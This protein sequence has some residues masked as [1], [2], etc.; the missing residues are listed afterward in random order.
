MDQPE[1][2][3]FIDSLIDKKNIS[4]LTDEA[5]ASIAGELKELLAQQINRAILAQ[6][7]DEKLDEL[8]RRMDSGN[9]NADD[10]QKFIN[11]SGVDIPKVTAETMLYLQI[12]ANKASG[13]HCSD[14][15]AMASAPTT[16][17]LYNAPFVMANG[18]RLHNA[19]NVK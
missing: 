4:G 11:N 3:A 17:I 16:A 19:K 18:C 2:G 13:S 1:V 12:K 6:L 8:N 7:S 15:W 14:A 9:F 5:R 10:V